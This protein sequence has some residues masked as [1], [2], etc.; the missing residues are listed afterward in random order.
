MGVTQH[1]F[2]Q[3]NASH[4][5]PTRARDLMHT[6]AR[7]HSRPRSLVVCC[8]PG[9]SRR[10]FHALLHIE[11]V[12]FILPTEK[13]KNGSIK[14]KQKNKNKAK[15]EWLTCV[16]ATRCH[17][18]PSK[19]K[20][21]YGHR[22]GGM[23]HL[24]EQNTKGG[25]FPPRREHENNKQ[26]LREDGRRNVWNLKRHKTQI[27]WFWLRARRVEKTPEGAP[28]MHKK[29]QTSI[30][31]CKWVKLLRVVQFLLCSCKVNSALQ[32]ASSGFL[33]CMRLRATSRF[34]S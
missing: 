25:I 4:G 18:T 9:R 10:K 29:T 16:G 17:G 23:W 20:A 31:T 12:S 13:W 8:V 28:P 27:V 21:E 19:V 26:S 15:W 22:F 7:T 34:W 14:K 2:I 5:S 24:W 1:S 33:A 30:N 11:N 3:A 32:N 6:R